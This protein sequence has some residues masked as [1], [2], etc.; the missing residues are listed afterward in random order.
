MVTLEKEKE[1]I[2]EEIESYETF[3]KWSN[4]FFERYGGMRPR[5][6]NWFNDVQKAH[7]DIREIIGDVRSSTI[8]EVEGFQGTPDV[9]ACKPIIDAIFNKLPYL[10]GDTPIRKEH[11]FSPTL[12]NGRKTGKALLQYAER[13]SKVQY[14]DPNIAKAFLDILN[15]DVA[16]LGEQWAKVKTTDQEVV[17]LI[18]TAA[19]AFVAL[20]HFGPD[21]N[22]CWGQSGGN[23]NHKYLL[24]T[25]P[26]TFVCL[27]KTTS[28]RVEEPL[29]SKTVLG[30]L[31]GFIR[32][33][34]VNFC[35]FYP[36]PGFCEGNALEICRGAAASILGEHPEDISVLKDKIVV[37]Q[38]RGI[39]HNH[40]PGQPNWSFY[41][42]GKDIKVQ[43]L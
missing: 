17:C 11:L 41:K 6:P 39:W 42:K 14:P 19:K 8:V 29:D 30:R 40:K 32:N 27:I 7:E 34:I 37:P 15:N 23:C 13:Y 33:D 26:D 10:Y 3:S 35:N 24:G 43:T 36:A 21:N 28:S 18:T 2:G 9:D 20:G 1:E 38:E 12:S 25:I 22:S 5:L 16:K 4:S 31:W